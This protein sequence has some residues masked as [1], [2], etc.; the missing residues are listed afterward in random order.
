MHQPNER[1]EIGKCVWCM[2]ALCRMKEGTVVGVSSLSG[3][4]KRT[5]LGVRY[6]LAKPGLALI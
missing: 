6:F 4:L 3:I 1:K 2:C 5:S